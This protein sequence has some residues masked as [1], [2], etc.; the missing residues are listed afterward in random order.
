MLM[1][2]VLIAMLCVAAYRLAVYALP[3]MLGLTAAQFAYQT[4]S[5]LVGAVRPSAFWRC[6]SK[7]TDPTPDRGA[8]L[9]S[10]RRRRRIC[11][12]PWHHR[13]IGAVQNLAANLRCYRRRF[14]RR[15]SVVTAVSSSL[16]KARLRLFLCLAMLVDIAFT[17]L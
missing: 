2:I 6:C 1:S 16:N 15:V 12:R 11:A 14:R 9:R 3:F 7:P 8:G 4:G 5:G 13:G 10:A 17:S